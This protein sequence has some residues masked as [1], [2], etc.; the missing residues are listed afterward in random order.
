MYIFLILLVLFC[1]FMA[2]RSL[3][4]SKA[5][6]ET[7]K[8]SFE[9]NGFTITKRI[10]DLVVDEQNHKWM[11]LS[12]KSPAIHDFSDIA[13]V[14]ISENGQKYKSQHGIMRAVVG[15]TVFGAADALVGAG[16]AS[17]AQSINHLSIDVY[18]NSLDNPMESF[19]FISSPTKTDSLLYQKVYEI[20]KQMSATLMAMQRMAEHETIG[21]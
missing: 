7:A 9:V 16:T 5:K 20:V 10:R 1:L 19:L 15:G 12:S 21:E 2:F 17:R 18:L 6:Q 13:S 11:A 14:E 8:E 4:K 3:S